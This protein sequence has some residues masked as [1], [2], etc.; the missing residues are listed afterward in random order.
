MS[1]SAQDAGGTGDRPRQLVAFIPALSLFFRKHLSYKLWG[2][3]EDLVHET[4][5]DALSGAAMTDSVRNL[6]AYVLGIARHKLQ[7]F[8]QE[9]PRFVTLDDDDDIPFSAHVAQVLAA[10]RLID[11]ERR[12]IVREE[13]GHLSSI[14]RRVL[15]LRYDDE[16]VSNAEAARRLGIP[17]DECSRMKYRALEKLGQRIAKRGARDA[18]R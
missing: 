4:L 3:I 5:L 18:R 13:L 6:K 10:A 16:G 15:E 1:D 7:R 14:E 11:R 17:P 8:I 12:K 9:T 2:H